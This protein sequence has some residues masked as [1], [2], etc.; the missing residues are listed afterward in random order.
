MTLNQKYKLKRVLYFIIIIFLLIS[1]SPVQAQ[2][3]FPPTITSLLTTN[4][5]SF[6]IDEADLGVVKVQS[7][8]LNTSEL[9]SLVEAL[10]LKPGRNSK[11]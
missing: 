7:V 3:N 8:Q 2:D 9:G 10:D 6:S 11:N 4:Q 5:N 1:S